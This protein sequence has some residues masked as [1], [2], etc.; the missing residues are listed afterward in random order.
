MSSTST[1]TKIMLGDAVEW[2]SA[3]NGTWAKKMGSVVEIVPTGKTPQSKIAGNP[4]GPR[5]HESYVVEVR[6]GI[7]AKRLYWP[8]AAALRVIG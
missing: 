1:S 8:R 6:T 3:S 5:E 2:A 7:R 4:G